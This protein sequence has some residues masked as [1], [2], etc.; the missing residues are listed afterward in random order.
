VTVTDDSDLSAPEPTRDDFLAVDDP[1]FT[2]GS[3]A[4]GGE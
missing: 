2:D 3:V 1:R 4:L